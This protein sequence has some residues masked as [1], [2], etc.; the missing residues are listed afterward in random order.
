[1]CSIVASLVAS[2]AMTIKKNYVIKIIVKI[3]TEN[4]FVERSKILA[5]YTSEK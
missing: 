1:M 2:V 3:Y 5:D 4:G